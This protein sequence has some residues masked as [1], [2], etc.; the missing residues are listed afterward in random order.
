MK[1]LP[2]IWFLKFKTQEIFNELCKAYQPIFMFFTKAGITNVNNGEAKLG[3]YYYLTNGS[4]RGKEI[5]YEEFKESF[6][7]N[8]KED[9]RYLIKFF[10]FLNIK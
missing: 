5:T 6:K 3:D 10:R 8:I 1:K 4:V 2:K 7:S 9:Y